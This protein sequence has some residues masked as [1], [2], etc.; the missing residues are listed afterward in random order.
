MLNAVPLPFDKIDRDL[1]PRDGLRIPI[2]NDH[3]ERLCLAQCADIFLRANARVDLALMHDHA[4][5]TADSIARHIGHICRKRHLLADIVFVGRKCLRN[6]EVTV[7]ICHT[8]A[9]I[10]RVVVRACVGR[11][12]HVTIPIHETILV[13]F[14]GGSEIVV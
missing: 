14:G 1:L 12:I 3:A 13:I 6:I 8:F 4:R 10:Y 2:E 5:T 7:F 11:P 9:F